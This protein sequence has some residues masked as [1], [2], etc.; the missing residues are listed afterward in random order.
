MT[1]ALGFIM[2]AIIVVLLISNKTSII[3]VFGIIPI[4]AALVLGYGLKDIQGFMNEGF[5]SVLNTII[6]FSFAVMF[7]S[8]LSDVGMFDVIV[9]RVMK[10]LGN[11]VLA[12]LYI[13]CF[14]TTSF[15]HWYRYFFAVWA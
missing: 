3:P 11:N 8:L 14:V 4:L 1:A 12:V 2:L 6:L 5:Q 7:F 15:P 13:A 9:N 10:Y